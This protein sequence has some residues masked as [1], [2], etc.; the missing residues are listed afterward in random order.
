MNTKHRSLAL[1][2]ALCAAWL[3]TSPASAQI[4]GG[5]LGG[6]AGG[7]LVGGPGFAVGGDLRMDASG[8]LHADPG[9]V[10]STADAARSHV[11]ERGST[12]RARATATGRQAIDVTQATTGATAATAAAGGEVT[13]GSVS[14]NVDAAAAIA[15]ATEASEVTSGARAV[16]AASLQRGTLAPSA[17]S[18]A[19]GANPDDQP[20]EAQA[21]DRKRAESPSAHGRAGGRA[22]ATAGHEVA[23]SN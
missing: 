1:G 10:R 16:Q 21:P 18:S 14:G 19:E 23:A 8:S 2:A 13:Q 7:S 20:T 15:T 6:G 11:S 9:A 4:L 22:S 12:T 3:W 5:S 17:G